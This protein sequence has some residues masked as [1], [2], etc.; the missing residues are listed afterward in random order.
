M[1][2]QRWHSTSELQKIL[3]V[4]ERL[5]GGHESGNLENSICPSG[6]HLDGTCTCGSILMAEESGTHASISRIAMLAEALFELGIRLCC[7]CW[8]VVAAVACCCCPGGCWLLGGCCC[9][10]AVRWLLLDA[11]LLQ[12]CCCNGSVPDPGSVLFGR[13]MRNTVGSGSLYLSYRAKSCLKNPMYCGLV[14]R[15]MRNTARSGSFPLQLR[16]H[17]HK[18]E[19]SY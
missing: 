6:F 2:E 9:N 4:W 12:C 18:Y 17:C 15:L 1:N 7:S 16:I 11:G 3:Q 14:C 19:L 8:S 13:K 5:R 10:V